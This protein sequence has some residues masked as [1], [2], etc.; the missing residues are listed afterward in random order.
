MKHIGS[1]GLVLVL[2]ACKDGGPTQATSCDTTVATAAP[3]AGPS[4]AVTFPCATITANIATTLAAREAGLMNVAALGAN[5][6]MLFV[7]AGPDTTAFWMANTQTALSIAFIDSN[8]Q[9]IN[10]DDMAP[11][12]LTLHKATR[13]YQYALEVNLGWFTAHNIAAG[14]TVTFALPAGTITD[15]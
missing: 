9:V 14:T 1:I 8:K 3:M 10:V 15:P 4:I 7:F 5:S 11:E 2:A 12:T 6:G 13:S